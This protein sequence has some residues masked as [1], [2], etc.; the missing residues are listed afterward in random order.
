[1]QCNCRAGMSGEVA[2]QVMYLPGLMP[3]PPGRFY[4]LFGK[5]IRTKGREE[6]LKDK[7]KAS[8]LYMEIKSQ[9]EGSMSYLLKKREEDPYRSLLDRA[10]YRA[11]HAPVDRVPTFEP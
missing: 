5:P 4:Y 6:M 2:N 11:F 7:E 9:V 1:M 8:E 3:K 10:I